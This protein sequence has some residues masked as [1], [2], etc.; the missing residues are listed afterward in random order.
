MKKHVEVF[1][2][3]LWMF[4]LGMSIAAVIV[5]FCV[6][7]AWLAYHYDNKWLFLLYIIPVGIAVYAI[8]EDMVQK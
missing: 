3:G 8:G 6:G 2:S 4:L 5:F 7:P 1:L